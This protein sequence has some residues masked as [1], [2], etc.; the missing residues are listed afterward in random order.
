MVIMNLLPGKCTVFI[1]RTAFI[2]HVISLRSFNLSWLNVRDAGQ[3][4]LAT[5]EVNTSSSFLVS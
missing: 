4:R 5:Q 2:M 3:W 1:I